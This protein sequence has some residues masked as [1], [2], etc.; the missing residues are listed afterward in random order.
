MLLIRAPPRIL[1]DAWCWGVKN[2]KK[3]DSN[4][5]SHED[6]KRSHNQQ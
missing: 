2:G 5:S 4:S 1:A 6:M 3:N